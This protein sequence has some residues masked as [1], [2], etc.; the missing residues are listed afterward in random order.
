MTFTMPIRA[1]AALAVAAAVLLAGL[2]LQPA[3]ADAACRGAGSSNLSKGQAS[4]AFVCLINKERA[5]RGLRKV[6]GN[7]RLARVATLHARDSVRYR[8][9]GHTS[10]K[11]GSLTRRFHRSGYRPGR[12]RVYF[13]EILGAGSGRLSSP[14]RIVRAWMNTSIHR[15]AILYPRFRRLGV[16][17]A[18][19]MPTNRRRGRNFVI[20]FAS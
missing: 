2:A 6:R 19:G 16:G 8:F 5:R 14:R 20:T 10:P 3:S 15:T 17:I 18:K 13:G 4:R 9:M 11:R 1:A 7:R 12:G